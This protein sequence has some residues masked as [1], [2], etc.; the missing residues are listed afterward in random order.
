MDADRETAWN[1]TRL[2][3]GSVRVV[4]RER[5]SA[6]RGAPPC[7]LSATVEDAD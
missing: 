1:V 3:R 5:E 2:F 4:N 6:D 7:L